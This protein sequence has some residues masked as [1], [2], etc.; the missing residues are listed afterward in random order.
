V[1]AG[2]AAGNWD[3]YFQQVGG[4]T[5]LNLTKDSLA[6]DNQPALSP[7]GTQI[8]FRS[9][10]DGGGI[11][12]MGATGENVRRLTDFGFHPAWS[13]DGTEIVCATANFVLPNALNS[14]ADQLFVVTVATGAK[15][16]VAEARDAHQPRWSPHGSRIAYWARRAG[17]SERDLWTIATSG[18]QPVPVTNDAATDWNPVWSDDGHSLYFAS[19][20]SGSMNLWRIPLDEASGEVLGPPEAITTPSSYSG[21][22]SIS[23]AGDIVY[24]Q[25]TAYSSLYRA[26]LDPVGEVV[27]GPP[28]PIIQNSRSFSG[29]QDISPDGQSVAIFLV[30]G[31]QEDVGVVRID[32]SGL[33]NLTN[34]SHKD[35]VPRWSPDGQQIAF[36]S[37]RSGSFEVWTIRADGSGLRQVTSSGGDAA[38]V[39]WAPDSGRIAF[40]R[41][42]RDASPPQ[43][44]IANGLNTGRQQTVESL[45]L[46]SPRHQGLSPT[47]WSPDGR[48]LALVLYDPATAVGAG[49]FIY[50]FESRHLEQLTDVGDGAEWFSDNRRLLV[51]SGSK[52][53]VLNSVTRH[54]RE[55]PG[56][57]CGR[58]CGRVSLSSDDRT[59]VYVQNTI[60][61]EIWLAARDRGPRISRPVQ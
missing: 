52:L 37:D 6:E 58:F 14:A 17:A 51:G 61:A 43:V 30:T 22:F 35:R 38:D 28:V 40:R 41:R 31:P 2:Q 12:V 19:D 33:R 11:F 56:V 3:I 32:G 34:D 47:S 24:A 20:R 48:R 39:V 4:R 49:V 55:I 26:A 7:D 45:P 10:R 5:T 8:A 18:G 21:W 57:L 44:L 16:L 60:E 59:I 25:R 15:R 13:P 27:V 50:N 53:Y 9:E 23:Q 1:Y 42:P 54:I 46:S 36:Y 29:I